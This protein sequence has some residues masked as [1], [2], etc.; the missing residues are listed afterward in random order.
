[1]KNRIKLSAVGDIAL[2]G[3][4]AENINQNDIIH[5]F[6][7]VRNHLFDADIVFGNLEMPFRDEK[8]EGITKHQSK[9][10]YHQDDAVD[11]IKQASF[12][13]LS[14]ANNHI[15]ECGSAGLNK[16]I[17]L[18][19]QND[20]KSVGAGNNTHEARKE[21]IFYINGIKIAFLAYSMKSENSA[22]YN[23][24]GH[25]TIMLKDML[26]D[27]QR[28]R[29][30]TDFVVISLH[31]G[32]MYMEMPMPEDIKLCHQLIDNGCDV[33]LGHHP[34]VLQGVEKH[35]KGIIFYS[36]GEFVF[37][38]KAGV[39]YVELGKK[40]R[41]QSMI[42]DLSFTSD[43]EITYEITPTYL[44]DSYIVE[45][46]EGIER[47]RFEEQFEQLCN[48]ISEKNDFYQKAGADLVKYEVGGLYHHLK[49]GNLTYIVEK[50]T[51]LK[52]KHFLLF[53]GFLKNK[54]NTKKQG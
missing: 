7:Y 20:I 24:S 19:K 18:L 34:H 27:L 53:I 6:Q 2:I 41:R 52:L 17:D 51:S 46:Q 42:V 54:L 44:S 22:Q 36:L 25:S 45:I 4:V 9:H 39:R 37:D 31:F 28:I 40:K 5:P 38:R 49:K 13:I 26:D 1:M 21:E 11:S 48:N 15:M 10:F 12:N 14:I 16:T 33:I 8:Q 3:Q 47:E 29:A 23:K 30:K 35:K 32:M 50:I 43:G